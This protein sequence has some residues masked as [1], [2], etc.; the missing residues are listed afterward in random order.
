[1]V[2]KHIKKR[3]ITFDINNKKITVDQIKVLSSKPEFTFDKFLKSILN[4]PGFTNAISSIVETQTVLT[5]HLGISIISDLH[6]Q[7]TE[8]SRRIS[9]PFSQQK[10]GISIF[11]GNISKPMLGFKSFETKEEAINYIF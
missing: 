4:K 7:M 3:T 9:P 1:M 10:Q 5:K 2:G 11:E 6:S 8:N